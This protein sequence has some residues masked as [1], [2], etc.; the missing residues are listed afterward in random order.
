MKARRNL[1]ASLCPRSLVELNHLD[2]DGERIL[3]SDVCSTCPAAL[4]L[5]SLETKLKSSDNLST[6]RSE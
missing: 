1:V 5:T 2:E 3:L 6:T 4:R